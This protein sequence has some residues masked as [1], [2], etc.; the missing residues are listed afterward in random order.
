M[1]AVL[2]GVCAVLLV[3]SLAFGAE[4][5]KMGLLV[6]LTG[7]AAADGT[8]ALY[9]VQIAMDQVNKD[10]GVLGKQIELVYYDDRA[11]AK[12]A[13][14][15]SYKLIEQDKIA[16]FVAGSYSLPTRAVAPIF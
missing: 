2:L 4:T 14:A 9:S 16:A 13:V 15:L 7:P 11:D 8:S 3:S 1:K 10:G 5:I 12:E 6:P